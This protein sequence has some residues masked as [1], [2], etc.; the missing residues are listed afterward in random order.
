M[1]TQQFIMITIRSENQLKK[2]CMVHIHTGLNPVELRGGGSRSIKN[3][4]LYR[5]HNFVE[6]LLLA[7]VTCNAM[8]GMTE[9]K[10]LIVNVSCLIQT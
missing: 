3:V 4:L 8:Q 6:L 10:R 1:R 9:L 2:I 5:L 7:C